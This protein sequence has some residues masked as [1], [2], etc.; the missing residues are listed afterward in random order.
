MPHTLA[1]KIFPKMHVVHGLKIGSAASGLRY[2]GRDDVMLAVLE[3]PGAIAGVLTQSSMPSH[4]VVWCR[5]ILPKGR[6]R[7]ILTIAGN[8]NAMNGPDGAKALEEC[9]KEVARHIGCDKEE[10]LAAQTGTIGEKMDPRP[11]KTILPT[12][13]NNVS[14][15]KFHDA[16]TAIMTTDTFPKAASTLTHIA[17]SPVTIT[18]FVKGSGM[19]AP[20]MA[21]LLA[22]IFTDANLSPAILQILAK[23]VNDFSFNCVSIDG[24]SSTS[25]SF[26]LLSTQ[27]ATHAPIA[28]ADLPE[29]ADFEKALM[30]I[31]QSL[32]RQLAIDGE[33]AKKLITLQVTGAQTREMAR[34]VGLSIVNSPLVKT[35]IA[36]E[37]GNWGRIVMAIGKTELPLSPDRLSISLGGIC[38]LE[39]G[40]PTDFPVEKIDQH[41]KQDE[42]NLSVDLG[43][44]GATC[45]LWSCDLT[46][47][48]IRINADYRS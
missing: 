28:R 42:I 30:T 35:A 11:V 19:I 45:R 48:Y 33:G 34:I 2:Q 39:K 25:D 7:A 47:N 6:A 5:H 3:R 24:D 44:G 8:A 12:L 4:P 14:A 31:A 29:L 17:G 32:A 46:E 22:Y 41:F 38:V 1:P 23:R 26:F 37:D 18:G 13:I 20:N 21:T 9:L 27:T 10:I 40:C 43:V 16:A 36:G 15:D